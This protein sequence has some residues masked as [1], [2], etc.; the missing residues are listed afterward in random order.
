[1]P[2]EPPTASAPPLRERRFAVIDTET[3]GL[4]PDRD[5]VVSVAVVPVHGQTVR[6]DLAR[7]ILIDPGRAIPPQATSVHGLTDTDVVGGP[8]LAGALAEL[9]T[10]LADG[11][12][13]GHNV[14]FDL[15]F[16]AAGG[17]VADEQL[18]TLAVSRLLWR[19]PG[20][21]HTLDRFAQRLGVVPMDRHSALGDAIATAEA[22]VA[23]LPMLA[24]RG[25]DSP[26]AVA[27]AYA[28][29]RMRRARV[30]RSKRRA[31]LARSRFSR[32]SPRRSTLRRPG[33]R[34]PPRR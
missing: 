2:T 25:L 32:S 16:L 20:S 30:R 12:V 19:R 28:A 14:D 5:A 9:S 7:Q 3:T 29:Q 8:D 23:C 17:F 18:D 22:L 4:D 15:A 11:I 33:H 10:M 34:S 6:R 26:Q 13:V 27:L 24:E 1:M 31:R 21:R